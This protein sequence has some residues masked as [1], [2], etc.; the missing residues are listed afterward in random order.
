V[1]FFGKDVIKNVTSSKKNRVQERHI[2]PRNVTNVTRHIF[3]SP[4][5]SD[6]CDAT[7]PSLRREP[8]KKLG[9]DRPLV[10]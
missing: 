6:K 3:L 1:T 9:S 2:L 7:Y 8:G 10:Q 4:K 5:K